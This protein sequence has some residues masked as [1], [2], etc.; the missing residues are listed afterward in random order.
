VHPVSTRD[1]ESGVVLALVLVLAL[2]LTTAVIT[3]ARRAMVDAM[4]VRNRD[5]AAQ[6]EALARGGVRLATEL[7]LE[8]TL[9]QSGPPSSTAIPTGETLDDLWARIGETEI[10]T[11]EGGRLH[12]QVRDANSRLNL[13][14][15]VDHA[16]PGAVP[17]DEAVEFLVDFLTKV[18]EEIPLPPSE[19]LYDPRELAYNLI[20]FIDPNEIRVRGGPEDDYYQQQDPPYRAWNQPLLSVDQL[21]LVEGFDQPLVEALR[22]YV[23]VYPLV[24][25]PDSSGINLNTAPPYVLASVYHGN[26]G[27]LHLADEDVVRRVLRARQEGRIL[28]TDTAADGRCMRPLEAGVDDHVF[29]P[30]TLP[31]Q[32]EAFLVEAEATVGEVHRTVEAVVDR[33]DPANPR[34]LFWRVR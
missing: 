19:K 14:A 33:S 5:A 32:S 17:S 11:P 26:E 2:L 7:L 1:R 8:D 9:A 29:P 34:L 4:I 18:I 12:L 23:T 27:D 21:R 22:P 10:T 6:A 15:L 13:N 24:P 30:V 16:D 3:F 28:C 31:S 20:D 25:A